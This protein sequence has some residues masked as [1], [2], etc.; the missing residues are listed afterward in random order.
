MKYSALNTGFAQKTATGAPALVVAAIALTSGLSYADDIF[1]GNYEY[2]TNQVNSGTA[3]QTSPIAQAGTG[4]IYKFGAGTWEIPANIFNGQTSLSVGV[5]EGSVSLTDSAAAAPSVEKPTA[6]LAKAAF[7]LDA[8]VADSRVEVSSNG[9]T[10]VDRWCDVRDTDT[11]SPSHLYAEANHAFT[12]CSPEYVTKDGKAA[13]YFGGLWSKRTMNWMNPGGTRF[14]T[15]AIRHVFC[16]HGI[17]KTWG[18]LF[19]TQ[20]GQPYFHI[21]SYS[22]A[23]NLIG[24]VWITSG[25]PDIVNGRTS[26]NGVAVNPQNHQMEKGFQL[27]DIDMGRDAAWIENF[28]NDRNNDKRQGG[29]YIC[30]CVAFTNALT[31]AERVQ[32]QAWLMDKWQVEP[33]TKHHVVKIAEGVSVEVPCAEE[34]SLGECEFLGSGVLRKTGSDVLNLD[35]KS[36]ELPGVAVRIEE[37]T[38]VLN[39]TFPVALSTGDRITS[40]SGTN[41]P[42]VS[43]SADAPAGTIVKE[44]N[45]SVLLQSLPSNL[46]RLVVSAGEVVLAS[47]SAIHDI[48]PVGGIDVAVPNG[49]FEEWDGKDAGFCNIS[50]DGTV[51]GW[52]VIGQGGDWAFF[53]KRASGVKSSPDSMQCDAWPV[54]G[55]SYFVLRCRGEVYTT[56]E[57]PSAGTYELSFWAATRYMT[58][59]AA[60]PVDIFLDDESRGVSVKVGRSIAVQDNPFFR[61]VHNVTVDAGGTW[62]LRFKG[63]GG[64]DWGATMLDDIRLRRI[65]ERQMPGWRIPGGDFECV[66]YANS[67]DAFKVQTSNVQDGWTLV[68][69]EGQS[70]TPAVFYSTRGYDNGTSGNGLQ[71]GHYH[72]DSRFPAGGFTELFF[73]HN[74][75]AQDAKATTT[76][77]PPAGT[78]RLVGEM[79][80]YRKSNLQELPWATVEIA[81]TVFNLGT[82]TSVIAGLFGAYEFPRS[83][84]VDGSQNV[85]LVIGM[86]S[87][88]RGANDQSGLIIDNLR[89]VSVYD[90]GVELVSNGGFESSSTGW[91]KINTGTSSQTSTSEGVKSYTASD[92]AAFTLQGCEGAKC[93]ILAYSNILAQTVNFP[94]AG[95][96]R[97]SWHSQCRYDSRD[98]ADSM[99]P[100][101]AWIAR[102]GVTN[103]IGR[104]L[105]TASWFT[106]HA[107]DFDVP[108]A[109]DWT[110]A[111]Q[112]TNG[113]DW[114]TMHL[115]DNISIKCIGESSEVATILPK[116]FEISIATGARM[117]LGFSGVNRIRHLKLGGKAVYGQVSAKTHPDYFYGPGELNVVPSALFIIVR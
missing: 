110:F 82:N 53:Y 93:Y 84:T 43:V 86:H 23:N 54:E 77:R 87:A 79:V 9:C 31:D 46:E 21:N 74:T 115:I 58:R 38:V 16:V 91:T 15:R 108:E 111:L 39:K 56:V 63:A 40:N 68:Q 106:Q 36:V 3:V 73:N 2:A 22:S 100:D 11:S 103:I 90:D 67:G 51:G 60:H 8:S 83:F 49:G 59:N 92:I 50:S 64:G 102:N 114:R 41:G 71:H 57:L 61:Q 18:F 5:L 113:K 65:P 97:L 75:L 29:D 81:G 112:G 109:G 99:N 72:N 4:T 34:R 12:N 66:T 17:D 104:G 52:T 78:Y 55:D 70:G 28:F 95:R 42:R 30:E 35:S 117:Q 6:V 80:G 85:M 107:F 96:Y 62:R 19:G 32:V 13:I 44:G 26:V 20:T 10:F 47:P 105:N 98:Y 48:E 24:N 25:M 88:D 116:T 27:I 101:I 1:V 37:G 69:P 89:L 14:T 7:W 33:L 76:F 94:A 45:D